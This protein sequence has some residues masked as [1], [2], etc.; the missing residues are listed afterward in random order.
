LSEKSSSES[1]NF[2][3]GSEF[4]FIA[5]AAAPGTETTGEAKDEKD[6]TREE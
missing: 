1:T 5:A 6:D 3:L 2:E 4:D